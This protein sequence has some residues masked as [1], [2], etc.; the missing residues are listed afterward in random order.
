MASM[1]LASWVFAVICWAMFG[2]LGGFIAER[3]GRDTGGAFALSFILGPIGLLIVALQKPRVNDDADAAK[4]DFWRSRYGVTGAVLAG[5]LVFVAGWWL[6][7]SPGSP[8]NSSG[9]SQQ[10][11]D[12]VKQSMQQQFDTDPRWSQYGLYVTEVRLIKAS[13]NEYHGMATVQT[14]NGTQ[15]EVSV[16]VTADSSNVMWQV[17]PPGMLPL[18]TEDT[19]DTEDVSPTPT[20]SP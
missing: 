2:C 11:A 14:R 16:N 3:K 13:G 12:S 10:V 5:V 4:P 19:E 8:V 7:Q 15:H 9:N 1:S 6:I 18:L 17:P 20:D